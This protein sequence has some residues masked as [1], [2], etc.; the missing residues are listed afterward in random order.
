MLR[1]LDVE[2][3]VC[4]DWS[5]TSDGSSDNEESRLI[6][7][8]FPVLDLEDGS[9]LLLH[10]SDRFRYLVKSDLSHL[11]VQV[12]TRKS[13]RVNSPRLALVNFTYGDLQEFA[14]AHRGIVLLDEPDSSAL[15]S[16][17]L[18]VHFDFPRH[19]SLIVHVRHEHETGCPAIIGYLFQHI[20]RKGT[21]LPDGGSG[22]FSDTVLRSQTF[23]GHLTLPPFNLTDLE[24]AAFTEQFFPPYVIAVQ[25]DRRVFNID[26]PLS[27]LRADIPIEEKEQFLK[28]MVLI[29]EQSCRTTFFEGQVYILNR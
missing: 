18:H 19:R 2:R 27:V 1:L 13:L 11:P 23:S 9:F 26:F 29:R 5:L 12:C 28:D 24:R 15:H 22:N 25:T 20:L 17:Y 7:H 10:D 21:Y 8:P 4:F 16:E 3:I 14:E 6:R